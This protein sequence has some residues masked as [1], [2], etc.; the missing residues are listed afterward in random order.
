MEKWG[1]ANYFIVILHVLKMG[2]AKRQKGKKGT[3]KLFYDRQIILLK[4]ENG[5]Q[6]NYFY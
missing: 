6:A 5:G 4:R 3:G 2:Q 1:Q